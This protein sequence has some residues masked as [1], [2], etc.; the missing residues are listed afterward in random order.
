MKYENALW[1]LATRQLHTREAEETRHRSGDIVA[2]FF[3]LKGFPEARKY[4]IKIRKWLEEVTK[5]K[6]GNRNYSY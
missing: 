4:W 5:Q 2:F 1:C 6:N 3:Q